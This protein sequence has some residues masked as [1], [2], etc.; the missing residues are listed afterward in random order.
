MSDETSPREGLLGWIITIVAVAGSAVGVIGWYILSNRGAPAFDAT[1]FDLSSAPHSAGPVGAPVA[2]AVPTRPSSGLEM[3]R[4]DKGIRIV[5]PGPDSAGP[6]GPGTATAKK[7]ESH[8]GFT[9]NARKHEG[10]VRRFAEMMTGK[11]PAVRQYGRDWM[12]YPDL[13]KLNDDYMRNRDP[14]AF[15][16]GLAKAPNLGKMLK[17]Y[18]GQP[19]IKEFVVE[20]MKQAPGE[21]TSSA[22]DVLQNDRLLKDLVANVAAGLGLPPSITALIKSTDAKGGNV[23]QNKVVKDLMSDPEIQKAMRNGGQ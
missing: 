21:L 9:R 1:G 6:S 17:K 5:G 11:Y 3:M 4:A 20:G 16:I 12:R 10:A 23:D 7:E 14:I 18:A 22:M 2:S 15:M 8:A 13:R 19:G